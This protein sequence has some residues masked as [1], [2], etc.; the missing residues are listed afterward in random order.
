MEP[1]KIE[2]TVKADP[3]LE[4]LLMAVLGKPH[5]GAPSKA[6]KEE[7]APKKEE[8]APGEEGT[9]VDLGALA[10]NPMPDPAPT[11]P[12]EDPKAHGDA[13]VAVRKAVNEARIRK[14]DEKA[15]ADMVLGYGKPL[16]E[17]SLEQLGELLKKVEAM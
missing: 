17:M 3:R 11:E 12:K 6:R 9:P 15:L 8:A 4:A 2:I 1:I 10:A 7:P 5:I 16:A 13:E 14:V